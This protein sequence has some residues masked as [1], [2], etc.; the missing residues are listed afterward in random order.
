MASLK[1]STEAGY[2]WTHSSVL[3]IAGHNDPIK[4]VTIKARATVLDA[5]QAGWSGPPYDPFRLAEILNINIEPREDV[6]DARTVSD[7]SG[8]L[9]IEFNPNRTPGR[10]NY[11]IA[12]EIAHTLFPDCA[13]SIRNR[14][15]HAE[16]KRDDWQLEMLCNLAA[17]EILMPIGSFPVDRPTPLS[18]DEML[19]LRKKF[20]ASTEA[21]LIRFA[22]TTARPCCAFA[23]RREEHPSGA[24]YRLDY[25]VSSRMWKVPLPSGMLLPAN[26][27]AAECTAIG[28]T[29][30]SDET[31]IRD[32]G[33]WRAEFLGIPPYPGHTYPRVVGLL[34]ARAT[35]EGVPRLKY[36]KGDA[37]K[38]RGSGT[39]VI[40]QLV[41]DKALSWGRGFAAAVAKKW[42][43]SQRRFTEW[44]LTRKSEFR[45]GAVYAFEVEPGL[46]I[47]SLVAQHG[48]G[49]SPTPRIR[50]AALEAC[51]EELRAK[52]NQLGASVHMP[53]IGSGEARGNWSLVAAMIDE[54]LCSAGV[55][56][57]VYDL[58]GG[59]P[60][61]KQQSLLLGSQAVN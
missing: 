4:V 42:P 2:R 6:L 48:Y 8:K 19:D 20:G 44:V 40:A 35:A 50:Y 15:T 32:E 53:R 10:V 39:R 43:K 23:A 41:N 54:R 55:S 52:A 46:H 25:S 47:A 37:T 11:S 18:I 36:L 31:W 17:A 28:Y 59:S 12:H 9:T 30:K 21:I 60:G 26:T 34:T 27:G 45:L 13:A 57:T 33:H 24:R 14:C 56:V 61:A 38:P 1:H 16:M 51:L 49:P 7:A 5:I 3:A 58:P 22:R 29:A